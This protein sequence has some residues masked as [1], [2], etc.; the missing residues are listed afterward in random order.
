MR[1][2]ISLVKV[3]SGSFKAF[4][5]LA[6]IATISVSNP[7]PIPII[8]VYLKAATPRLKLATRL[9]MKITV[10]NSKTVNPTTAKVLLRKP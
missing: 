6:D 4:L 9:A 1:R 3:G 7:R 5:N 2:P 10:T 8:S